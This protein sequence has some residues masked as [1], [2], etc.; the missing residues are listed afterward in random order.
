MVNK[1]K[2][3]F[4]LLLLVYTFQTYAQIGIN[5]E[6]IASNLL[7][8]IDP[9]GNNGSGAI[10]PTQVWDDVV[11]D[12]NTGNVGLGTLTPSVK[13]EIKTNGTSMT[14]N[15]QFMLKDGYQENNYV[16]V[17]DINGLGKWEAYIPG[18]SKGIFGSGRN[19]SNTYAS[20]ISTYATISLLPGRWLIFITLDVKTNSSVFDLS[21][22][23]VGFAD[24][25]TL[26]SALTP[27]SGWQYIGGHLVNNASAGSSLSGKLFI[28]NISQN[29]KVYT[30]MAGAAVRNANPANATTFLAVGSEGRIYAFRVNDITQ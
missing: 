18:T 13:L 21:W 4:T 30:L 6:N 5:T 17:S 26:P 29:T 23:S 14:P 27:D 15:K 28:N 7:L 11:I 16:L 10:P 24:A 1:I 9:L 22:L 19:I 8:H 20:Y 12:K 2:Y 25:A 3:I